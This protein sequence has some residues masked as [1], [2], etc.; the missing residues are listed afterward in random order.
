M[1]EYLVDGQNRRVAKK[2]NGTFVKKWLYR[3]Q[4]HPAAELDGAGN[5]VETFVYATSQNAPD[6]VVRGAQTLRI[7]MATAG[8]PTGSGRY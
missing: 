2:K 4:L 3:D 6:Y 1:I 5:L 8:S 7:P